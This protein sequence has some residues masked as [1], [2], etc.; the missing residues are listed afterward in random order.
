MDYKRIRELIP[1]IEKLLMQKKMKRLIKT[2]EVKT[3]TKITSRQKNHF[4]T[5][6]KSICIN[7]VN[8]INKDTIFNKITFAFLTIN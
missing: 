4:L 1:V 8:E 3:L 7:I 5:D 2:R 6:Q